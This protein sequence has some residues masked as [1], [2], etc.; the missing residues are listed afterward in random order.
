MRM[1]I[2]VFEENYENFDFPR[3]RGLFAGL[4]FSGMNRYKNF[5]YNLFVIYAH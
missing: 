4:D 1:A 2:N 5:I 3:L